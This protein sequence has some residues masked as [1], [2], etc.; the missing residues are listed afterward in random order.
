MAKKQARVKVKAH[1]KLDEANVQHVINLLEAE[2]PITKKEAC[3]I[4]NIN[5]STSR[6]QRIIDQH[7]DRIEHERKM[8]EN[9]RGKPVSDFERKYIVTE[10]LKGSPKSQIAKSLYRPVALVERVVKQYS[11]P[12]KVKGK[13]HYQNPVLLPD[14]VISEDYAPNEIAWSARYNCAVEII[15]RVHDSKNRGPVYRIWVYGRFNEFANQP[16]YELGKLTDV[17]EKLN[18]SKTD[19]NLTDNIRM[20]YSIG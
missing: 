13:D 15:K 8:R 4:L 17:M 10:S 20:E 9:N 12:E 16:Y 19:L 2:K 11:L 1:E 5:Y 6:L 18:I 7:K 3:S 14:E